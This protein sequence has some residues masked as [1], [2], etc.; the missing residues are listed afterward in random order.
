MRRMKSTAIAS[1]AIMTIQMGCTAIVALALSPHATAQESDVELA[2]KLANPISSLVSL[3]FQFNYNC[4][5]G[6][7][8][9]PNIH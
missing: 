5:I 4:C 3:P 2:K 1:T 9:R 6:R 8:R 7:R